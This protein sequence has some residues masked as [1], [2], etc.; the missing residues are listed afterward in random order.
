MRFAG[1]GIRVVEH[2]LLAVRTCRLG[3]E[4]NIVRGV[5]K[6]FQVRM[7]AQRLFPATLFDVKHN[8][9]FAC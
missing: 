7:L 2:P 3:L 4:H 5:A 9:C 1:I 8:S 6:W